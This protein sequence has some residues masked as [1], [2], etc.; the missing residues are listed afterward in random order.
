MNKSQVKTEQRNRRRARIRAKVFG[1]ETRPRLS[2]FK[3][4]A[5]ISAQLIDDVHGVTLVSAHSKTV[6]GKT[7]MEKAKAVGADVAVKAKAKKITSAV[8]DR[9]GYSYTG[10]VKAVAEGARESG[11]EF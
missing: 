6:T 3:S 5:H 11:L 2:V 10:K 1:T 9:G 7:L 4:N 8:F